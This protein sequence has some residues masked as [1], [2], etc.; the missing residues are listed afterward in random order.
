MANDKEVNA[1]NRP[2]PDKSRDDAVALRLAPLMFRYQPENTR[3]SHGLDHSNARRDLHR[4]RD[5]RLPAGGVLIRKEPHPANVIRLVRQVVSHSATSASPSGWPV[6]L[7]EQSRVSGG[8]AP[9]FIHADAKRR[10]ALDLDFRSF[11][12][13]QHRP[14]EPKS[15]R[16]GERSVANAR[17][18]LA[19]VPCAPQQHPAVCGSDPAHRA[20]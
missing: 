12:G 17:H 7:S 14:C 13:L 8:T 9:G 18:C 16:L 19:G 2:G 6:P 10:G 20:N 11:C 1:T 5:Q 3:K 4:P 15:L